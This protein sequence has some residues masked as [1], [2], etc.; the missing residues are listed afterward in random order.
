M[1]RLSRCSHRRLLVRAH[2]PAFAVSSTLSTIC[3]LAGVEP[4][5]I[6]IPRF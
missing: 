4:D 1:V 3:T 2:C 5:G 6:A